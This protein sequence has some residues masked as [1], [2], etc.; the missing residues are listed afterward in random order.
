MRVNFMRVNLMH[1]NLMRS[2]H[3][4]RYMYTGQAAGRGLAGVLPE[5]D[6]GRRL[7]RGRV[8]GMDRAGECMST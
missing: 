7:R 6:R 2:A 1:V 4:R 3:R 8:G 5:R